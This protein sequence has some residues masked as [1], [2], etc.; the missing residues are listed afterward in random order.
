M[1]KHHQQSRLLRF[2]SHSDLLPLDGD[3]TRERL[4]GDLTG[5]QDR[6]GIQEVEDWE[7]IGCF[8][9]DTVICRSLGVG[10]VMDVR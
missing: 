2:A 5:G 8:G 4:L 9:T 7:A 10:C 3:V 1:S 6:G